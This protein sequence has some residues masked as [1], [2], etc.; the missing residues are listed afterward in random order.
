MPKGREGEYVTKKFLDNELHLI[1]RKF[2]T[3]NY[4]REEELE[5]IKK[6]LDLPIAKPKKFR[7]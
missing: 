1:D 4:E 2:V 5:K 7:R 3:L 6:R